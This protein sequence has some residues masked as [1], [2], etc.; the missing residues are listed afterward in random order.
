MKRTWTGLFPLLL[1]ALLAGTAFWLERYVSG[2]ATRA[3]GRFRHDPDMVATRTVQE[4]F[5]ATGKRLYVLEA[6]VARHY[7]DDDSTH[8]EEANLQHFGKPQTLHVTARQARISGPGDEVF[9][10]GE[11]RGR[12]DAAEGL[13]EMTFET[14][15]ITVRPD[16]EKAV[17]DKPV[18][19]TRGQSVIDGVGLEIDQINGV[20]TI[21]R[22][23]A[24]LY[25][26]TK[27]RGQ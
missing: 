22:V 26:N 20:A 10:S 8:V 12:R 18:H 25:R 3:D 21:G 9:L 17:T 7:P 19:M 2:Q 23:R 1:A 24:T 11:V 5:D 6:A 14:S 4:R 16:E 27:G 15:E 13:P